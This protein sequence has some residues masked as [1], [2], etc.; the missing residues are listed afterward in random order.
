MKFWP[1][2]LEKGVSSRPRGKC[3]GWAQVDGGLEVDVVAEEL[4]RL[5]AL[6]LRRDALRGG[7]SCP[8]EP[9]LKAEPPSSAPGP[10][11]ASTPPPGAPHPPP[12]APSASPPATSPP[13]LTK[14]TSLL[15]IG[16]LKSQPEEVKQKAIEAAMSSAPCTPT[17]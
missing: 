3:A 14:Q 4:T 6:K 12:G 10:S 13:K 17:T 7:G 16:M 5:A 8:P 1:L 9:V 2:N 11:G 15:M